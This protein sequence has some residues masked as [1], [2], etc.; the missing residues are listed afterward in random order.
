M[1]KEYCIRWAAEGQEKCGL[2]ET[3]V[4]ELKRWIE[5]VDEHNEFSSF[6]EDSLKPLLREQEPGIKAKVIQDVGKAVE[7]GREKRDYGT[8]SK[9]KTA[10][11][12]AKKKKREERSNAI[13]E[14][15]AIA[16]LPQK[17]SIEIG[18]WY[19]LEKHLL[20]CGDSSSKEFKSKAEKANFVF[21]D[22]PYNANTAEWDKDF[23][24]SHDWLV[25]IA[26]IVVVTP[27]IGNI[28]NFF[29]A[30][31]MPY[32]WAIAC[33]IDNGMTRGAVGFGNWIFLSV[34]SKSSVY[35][36]SQDFLRV[37]IKSS[38]SEETKHKGRK[39]SALLL[40]LLETFTSEND[41]VVDPFLGSG[42]TLF[43]AEEMGRRCIGAE[44]RLDF[45]NEIIERWSAIT[46]KEAIKL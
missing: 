41:V 19:Q 21:A 28:S 12:R 40:W 34:F 14:K 46:G 11:K 36:N 32:K 39:P 8:E 6:S 17:I 5:F 18:K 7:H 38:E 10:I 15:M 35:R 22:P 2:S 37:S 30:T 31:S 1:R 33:W 9:M 26:P 16:I 42:T 43:V 29:K 20:F 24:W 44:I 27:G 4:R 3:R 25:G 13:E 23:K 45:C